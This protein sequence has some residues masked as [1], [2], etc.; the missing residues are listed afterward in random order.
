M[1][2]KKY[3]AFDFGAES[4]RAILGI[5]KDDKLELQ[6]IHR[7]ANRQ[8]K[9]HGHIYWDILALFDEIKKGMS[10]AAGKGHTV[11][12]GIGV[13]TWGV[14]FG[15]IARND[16]MLG[17]PYAYRDCRTDGM[18]E[19]AFQVMP[20]SE[21]YKYSG[22]QFMQLNT[23]FQ[24]FSM[25]DTNNPLLDNCE[26]LLFIPDLFNFMMTGK[27]VTEYSIASTS[28]LIDA[29][30][31]EWSREIFAQL[32]LPV[33]IMAPI[34]KPGTV[35]GP[36]LQEICEDTGLEPADVIAPACHDTASAVASVPAS[37][38]NWAFLSSGTWSLMGIESPEPIINDVS[39]KNNFTNEGGVNGM[40][41]FLKNIMGLWLLQSCRRVWI[42]EGHTIDYGELMELAKQ[43]PAFRSLVDPDDISFL[44]PPDMTQAIADF[45][46]K[47]DQPVPESHGQYARCVL[48]S[49]AFKY[50]Y[51]VENM[52]EMIDEPIEQ[53]NIVGGGTKNELLNQFVANATGLPVIAGPVEATAIGNILVQAIAKKHIASLE[54]GREIVKNSFPLLSYSPQ[55]Q[56]VWNEK[57]QFFLKLM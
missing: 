48:E 7:F 24:L 32:S 26:T 36:L 54:A 17:N 18:M 27:K 31:K 3:L 22:I 52:N 5:L 47:T 45:C 29:K 12:D 21:I 34:V 50:R 51:T 46:K 37:G 13:D 1:S 6:E 10:I 57:Y 41:R 55:Q 16:V 40:I 8:V 35:V 49:L 33:D 30:T 25:V 15:L 38:K 23:I 9:M 56:D 28:Q 4:G 14:D 39:L 42:K 11:L 43:A 2:E 20:E 44:N 19:K 53:V